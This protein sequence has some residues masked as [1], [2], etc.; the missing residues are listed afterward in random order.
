MDMQSTTY[1]Q[2]YVD[3]NIT[4]NTN[5][6]VLDIIAKLNVRNDSDTFVCIRSSQDQ[7]SLFCILIFYSEF[8]HSHSQSLL[9]CVSGRNAEESAE[10]QK[11]EIV[12]QRKQ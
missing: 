7:F 4:K 12:N 2:M 3:R 9:Y 6:V 11:R 10:K 8:L 5:T 1:I